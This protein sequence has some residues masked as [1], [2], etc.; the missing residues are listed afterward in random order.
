MTRGGDRAVYQWCKAANRWGGDGQ[1]AQT[2][3]VLC[4]Q[5][6]VALGSAC[7]VWCYW[8]INPDMQGNLAWGAKLYMS[9]RAVLCPVRQ[10]CDKLTAEARCNGTKQHKTTRELY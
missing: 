6:R 7:G 8:P 1:S 5:G 9:E 2:D 10:P 3:K 4:C